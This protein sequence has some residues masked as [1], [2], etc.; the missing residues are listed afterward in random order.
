MAIFNFYVVYLK[1]KNDLILKI[2]LNLKSFYNIPDCVSGLKVIL[3]LIKY[4][5]NEK[6]DMN[7]FYE[8]TNKLLGAL[9]NKSTNLNKIEE[10][11]LDQER[12]IF[13]RKSCE[14]LKAIQG[15]TEKYILFILLNDTFTKLLSCD[16]KAELLIKECKNIVENETKLNSNEKVTKNDL[17]KF[18]KL[19]SSVIL[20]HNLYSDDKKLEI[21]LE[22]LRVYIQSIF[23]FSLLKNDNHIK[24]STCISS[25]I[26][27]YLS[28]I[29]S[30]YQ[31]ND[32]PVELSNKP[33]SK[34]DCIDENLKFYDFINDQND[35]KNVDKK[36][37]I[38][39][40]QNE[41]NELK[42]EL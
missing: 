31:E 32:I 2:S 42:I 14:F 30:I 13:I 6:N 35:N 15:N 21:P 39:D 16:K 17:Q 28:C 38:T 18:F 9:Y 4:L 40:S 20:F 41:V 12:L 19:I 1:Q 25:S 11:V 26:I 33:D 5:S 24:R 7:E 36:S 34:P 27:S 23:N 8:K 37:I 29:S 22:N 3:C 10:L